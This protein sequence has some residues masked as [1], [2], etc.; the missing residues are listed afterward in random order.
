[1]GVE[2]RHPPGFFVKFV[3]CWIYFLGVVNPI[4]TPPPKKKKKR[5]FLWPFFRGRVPTYHG[6]SRRINPGFCHPST[7]YEKGSSSIQNPECQESI[8]RNVRSL[9]CKSIHMDLT[10]M[11]ETSNSTNHDRKELRWLWVWAFLLFCVCV[12]LQKV[13]EISMQNLVH[14]FAGIARNRTCPSNLD[15]LKTKTRCQANGMPWK[16]ADSRHFLCKHAIVQVPKSKNATIMLLY[17]HHFLKIS[18]NTLRPP[19]YLRISMTFAVLQMGFSVNLRVEA[20]HPSQVVG[21]LLSPQ[22][23]KA[24]RVDSAQTFRKN[25]AG[26]RR[27]QCIDRGD[28]G[29]P[30]IIKALFLFEGTEFGTS[31]FWNN[32]LSL[33]LKWN[34]LFKKTISFVEKNIPKAQLWKKNIYWI[35]FHDMFFS[36]WGFS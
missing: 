1:M 15:T 14:P 18:K 23:H 11:G 24:Q 7:W 29:P 33:S 20:Q 3:N 13:K 27:F 8:K 2:V 6:W 28:Q 16:I 10:C 25:A 36:I 35:L 30:G 22:R 34:T 32:I 4:C 17:S 9:K 5:L 31:S 21:F 19:S 26:S 12:F